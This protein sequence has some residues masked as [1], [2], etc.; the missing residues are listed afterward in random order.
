MTCCPTDTHC[1][2]RRI[3][4]HL[5]II[6]ALSYG[7]V[8]RWAYTF[9]LHSDCR[10]PYLPPPRA[11]P[12]LFPTTATAQVMDNDFDTVRV[13]RLR[14]ATATNP[15]PRIALINRQNCLHESTNSWSVDRPWYKYDAVDPAIK[16]IKCMDGEEWERASRYTASDPRG[17]TDDPVGPVVYVPCQP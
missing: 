17:T 5:S 12:H 11:I 10:H 1:P 3:A 16:F 15:H 2:N 14:T 13:T 4:I 8:G 6:T 7:Q 9:P